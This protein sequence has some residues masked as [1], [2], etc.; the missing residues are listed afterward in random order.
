MPNGRTALIVEEQFLIALDIERMLAALGF[1]HTLF[2]RNV[3]EVELLGNHW[4]DISFAIVEV[5]Q[6]DSAAPKLVGRLHDAN[7]PCVLT[8]A[9]YDLGAG[10][11]RW[12]TLSILTKPLSEQDVA[13]AVERA[14]GARS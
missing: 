2:A 12:P 8:T 13:N 6:S 1:S 3:A 14:L 10:F 7:I 11:Y 5:R 4:P 9:D